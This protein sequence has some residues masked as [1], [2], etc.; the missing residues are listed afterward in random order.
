MIYVL[1]TNTVTFILKGD[2]EVK[3]NADIALDKGHSLILPQIVDYEVLRGLLAKRMDKKLREYLSFR[4]IVSIGVISAEV[5]QKAAQIFAILSQK[6]KPIGDGDIL[7][8]AFC[9]VNNCI[10]ITNDT[11]FNR[12]DSLQI[13]NWKSF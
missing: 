4:Q 2:A 9:L 6:G 5:W 1:D 13:V 3:H 12:V 7:V 8:A 10:L 11:D